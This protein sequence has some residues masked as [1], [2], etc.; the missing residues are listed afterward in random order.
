[1]LPDF[2]RML[3]ALVFVLGLMG[4]LALALKKMGLSGV[5]ERHTPGAKKRLRIVEALPID[6]RRRIVL[7]QRDDTQHL[8]IL[9]ASGETV[10]ETGIKPR[11]N[12][13]H[14]E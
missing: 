10:I 4:A 6:G 3:A 13:D 8:V 1:M 12:D 2:I 5:I 9:G 7:L 14:G 11:D